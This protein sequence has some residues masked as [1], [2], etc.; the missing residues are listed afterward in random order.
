MD[1]LITS[2]IYGI[3][4]YYIH[5]KLRSAMSQFLRCYPNYIVSYAGFYSVAYTYFRIFS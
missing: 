4:E 3:Y 2:V 1:V 5:D